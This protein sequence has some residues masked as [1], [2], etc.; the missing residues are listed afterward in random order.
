M[1]IIYKSTRIGK[2]GKPFTLY[3][4]RTM[5]ENADKIGGH[6]TSADDPRLTKIGKFLRKWQIDELPQIWN[7]IKRDM[8][9][10]GCRPE[11]PSE[12]ETLDEETK[13]IILSIKPGLTSSASL[14]NCS[15]G[16]RLRGSK[17]PHKDYCE[18]I[19]PIKM[20]LNVEY[21]KSKSF[22]G[23]LKLIVQTLWKI[24]H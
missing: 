7:I 18:K 3:K 15:E 4:F 19:K 22:M 24:I 5:V 1:S 11:V 9:I 21:V 12:I 14:W 17:D 13:R 8:N 20:R 6:S 10:V 23:D 16:E 2:N